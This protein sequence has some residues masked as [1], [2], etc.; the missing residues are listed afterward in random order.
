MESSSQYAPWGNKMHELVRAIKSRTDWNSE[1]IGPA[2]SYVQV[3]SEF[4]EWKPLL[5]T[6]LGKSLDAFIVTNESDRYRLDQMLKRYGVRANIFVRRTER[7]NYEA[8][9]ADPSCKSVLDML[10]VQSDTVLYTLIDSNSIE[11]P[12]YLTPPK[13][14]ERLVKEKRIPKFGSF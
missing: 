1:P 3:K 4:T 11:K 8:G 7:L 13:M 10:H 2:G 14:Q 5:S 6:V 9:K 12:S